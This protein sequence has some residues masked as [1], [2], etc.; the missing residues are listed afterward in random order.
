MSSSSDHASFADQ[1]RP[2]PPPRDA[3]ATAAV[4]LS[5]LPSVLRRRLSQLPC[6]RHPL[7]SHSCTSRTHPRLPLS[8]LR[9]LL[10]IPSLLHPSAHTAP[11][12]SI[13]IAD[14]EIRER[15]RELETR[16]VAGSEVHVREDEAVVLELSRDIDIG[17]SSRRGAAAAR[18]GRGVASRR[19]RTSSSPSGGDQ[20]QREDGRSAAAKVRQIGRA[21]V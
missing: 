1:A 16:A 17:E 21:H 10:Q 18:G 4:Q 3:P 2:D 8:H 15:G 7:P 5:P 14:Y 9:L 11:A 12:S 19:P 6:L 20:D 13:S